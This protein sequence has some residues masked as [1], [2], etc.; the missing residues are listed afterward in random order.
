MKTKILAFA[1][2]ALLASSALAAT[3]TYL[4]RLYSPGVK[5]ATAVDNLLPTAS[6][7]FATWNPADK[8]TA[9]I[10]SPGN[11]TAVGNGSAFASVRA[12]QSESS[13]KWYWES[14][15]TGA[16]A[17][18]YGYIMT[19]G[20]S[21]FDLN[22]YLGTSST[23]NYFGWYPPQTPSYSSSW[24]G[25]TVAAPPGGV[26][27]PVGTTFMM[28]MDMDNHA[29]YVG[30]NGTWN[31]GGVPTSGAA[32]TGAAVTGLSGTVFPAINVVTTQSTS[33]F[34]ATAFKYAVPT[35]YHAGVF[36]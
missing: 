16:N 26:N 25:T 30:V 10:L 2:L 33:N 35:G 20:T 3:P 34:G 19:A 5:G 11:L 18:N 14:T 29:L 12:T 4:Y 8:G 24:P 28:A 22:A 21:T 6:S 27:Y 36:Q 13:G 17:T 15:I 9:M 31:G 23:G 7:V 1:A 32:K